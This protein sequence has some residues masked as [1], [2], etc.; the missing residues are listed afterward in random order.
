MSKYLSVFSVLAVLALLAAQPASAAS[1]TE[2]LVTNARFTVEAMAENQEFGVYV[3]K[4][5]KNA[6]GVL[7]IPS[8]VKGAFMFG[9]EGGSGVMLVRS[10]TGVWS[11]PAFYT[12]GSVSWG[13]QIGGSVSEVMLLL[14][15]DKGVN[16]IVDDK[17]L[18]LGADVGV[19]LGPV[20]GGAEAGVTLGSV[21]V[22]VY[23]MSKGLYLGIS[24]EGSIIEP[25]EGLNEEYYGE[26]VVTRPIVMEAKHINPHA[27]NLRDALAD[28]AKAEE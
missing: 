1:K 5:M 24:L 9:G 4:F 12:L 26:L 8:M 22:M 23:S 20:G 7:V 6:K 10:E 13:L 19:A 25:R 21:D 16:A 3:R 15:T 28:L 17:K 18:K 27:D 14:M 11:Y 2:K